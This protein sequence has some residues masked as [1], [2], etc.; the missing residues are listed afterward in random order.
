MK[1]AVVAEASVELSEPTSYQEAVSLNH[2]KHRREAIH[3]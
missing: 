1:R 3:T 2:A